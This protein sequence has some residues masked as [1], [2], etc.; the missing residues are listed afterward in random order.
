M[1]GRWKILL[2]SFPLIGCDT[3]HVPSSDSTHACAGAGTAAAAAVTF[4]GSGGA[5]GGPPDRTAVAQ[6]RAGVP[7]VARGV[8]RLRLPRLQ[9]AVDGEADPHEQTEA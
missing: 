3:G 5:T 8:S 6:W 4:T 9:H 7:R 2:E 1:P